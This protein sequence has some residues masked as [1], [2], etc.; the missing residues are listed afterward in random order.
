MLSFLISE[1]LFFTSERKS[2]V[3]NKEAI[4]FIVYLFQ[5]NLS[6]PAAMGVQV[7]PPTPTSPKPTSKL[8]D[9]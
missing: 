2:Q 4:P 6:K 3:N 5:E 8:W 7:Q 1:S 9:N